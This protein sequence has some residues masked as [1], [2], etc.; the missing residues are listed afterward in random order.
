MQA[1]LK[2]YEGFA[3]SRNKIMIKRPELMQNWITYFVAVYLAKNY[4]VALEVFEAIQN[5]VENGKDKALKPHELSEIYMFKAKIYED[6]KAY[7]KG[8]KFLLSKKATS[9]ILDDY[10]K[11]E[12]LARLY[13]L[14]N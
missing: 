7:R 6:M 11:Y 10:T 14:N 5:Q 8:I 2:D 13:Y 12:T 9:I 3:D 4:D 1:Q